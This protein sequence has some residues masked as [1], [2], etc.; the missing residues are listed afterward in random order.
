MFLPRLHVEGLVL[1]SLAS[2]IG[3]AMGRAGKVKM[4]EGTLS[5]ACPLPSLSRAG[6]NAPSS[7]PGILPPPS[8]SP[9]LLF[10]CF[11]FLIFHQLVPSPPPLPTP[12][13][14]PSISF[15]HLPFPLL[16]VFSHCPHSFVFPLPPL[17]SSFLLG[18]NCLRGEDQVNL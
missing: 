5:P 16:S 4:V 15:L 12:L 13:L 9:H 7:F 10:F 8:T 17:P 3:W 18:T 2:Q 6:Q 1:S 11:P 14:F